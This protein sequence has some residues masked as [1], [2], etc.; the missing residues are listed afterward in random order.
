VL[1][2]NPSNGYVY[3]VDGNYIGVISSNNLVAE[4]P[5]GSLTFAVT[6]SPEN[7]YVY[8]STNGMISVIDPEYDF[9]ISNLTAPNDL[10]YSL[11]TYGNGYI[12]DADYLTNYTTQV[13]IIG[14]QS[15]QKEGG[16]ITPHQ[17]GLL[18][19]NVYNYTPG[20]PVVGGITYGLLINSENQVVEK[21]YI[22]SYSQLVFTNVTPGQYVVDV[23]H[24]PSSGVNTTEYWGNITVNVTSL[25]YTVNFIRNAPVIYSL[26][27]TLANGMYNISAVI[28]NPRNYSI[29]ATVYFYTPSSLIPASIERYLA[30]GYNY[31]SLGIPSS[32]P[33]VD[34]VVSAYLSNYLGTPIPTDEK[35]LRFVTETPIEH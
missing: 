25:P 30:P 31:F 1:T 10:W 28:Y 8:V 3:V 19:V 4:I 22:N 24:I 2:Y 11:M 21:A 27:Y 7:N 14:L 16:I 12:Y 20:F 32:T 5:I 23:Y 33:Y 13:I 29:E 26:N 35:V 6:Y 17:E 34:V 15:A 18:I 9:V